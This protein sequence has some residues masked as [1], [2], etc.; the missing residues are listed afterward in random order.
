MLDALPKAHTERPIIVFGAFDRHNFGDMLFA[1]VIDGLLR[2]HRPDAQPIF[3]G[4]AARDMRGYGGHDVVALASLATLWRG[5]P[6]SLIHAGGEVLTCDAWEAAVMLTRPE[7]TQACIARYGGRTD[8]RRTWARSTLGTDAL[9]P[10]VIGVET[11][12][13]ASPIGCNAIGGV[14]LE[15]RDAPLRAEVLTK[16]RDADFLCVR[17]VHTQATLQAAG[18]AARLIPD[19]VSIIAELFDARIRAHARH[20]APARV[21]HAFP[22]GYIAVQFS[23]DFGDDATLARLAR[24][25]DAIG[26]SSGLGIAL[27][28]AGA[29]PW[30]DDIAV[31][32]RLV[33]RM[34]HRSVTI[35]DSLDI[36]DICA[37]V[38]NSAGFAGSS[39]H[40]R[41]VAMAYALPRV[42][43]LHPDDAVR[44]G[45]QAAY[46]RTWEDEGMPH[47][48][49]I[50][51]LASAIHDALR[52]DR[53]ALMRRAREL[54]SMYRAGVAPLVAQAV[55]R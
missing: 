52:A 5:A 42:N 7:H 53:D 34:R 44:T 27:F 19:P 50:E 55:Q 22:H 47:A 25:F 2:E 16:L 54:A 45:K 4:L 15:S 8:D 6:V 3:A 38:A 26:A 23:A 13:R 14:A 10:Y 1:H 39:L 43:I 21:L 29:A 49:E 9:A 40:G 32:R 41:I 24:Q 36:W 37:L 20:G 30:H 12:G 17:D 11:F 18:I 48:V 33:A 28:R 51:Q 46:A 35:F 31:Y